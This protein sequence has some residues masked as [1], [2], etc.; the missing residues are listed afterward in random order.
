MDTRT[1]LI[2]KAIGI[3]RKTGY[4]GFSYADL[5]DAVG[6]RKASIHHH[7]PSKGDLGVAMVESYRERSGVSSQISSHRRRNVQSVYD[8]TPICIAPARLGKGAVRCLGRRLADLP[9]P[10]QSAV[11][12]F[13][14]DNV[15]WLESV[16]AEGRASREIE[17][18]KISARQLAPDVL[19]A[20]SP[21][22]HAHG[23]RAGRCRSVQ[24]CSIH[25]DRDRAGLNLFFL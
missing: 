8:V 19:F 20:T 12:A 11:R 13:F 3:V 14:D 7:F 16:I 18:T 22:R 23:A 15:A 25:C 17:R 1:T 2:D 6:I 9:V 4:A 21:G 10:V 5:S 24:Y